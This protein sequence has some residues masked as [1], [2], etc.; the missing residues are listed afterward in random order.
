[1]SDLLMVQFGLQLLL[2]LGLL[3]W[4]ALRRHPSRAAW[5]LALVLTASVVVLLALAGLWL[6]LPWYLPAVYGLLLVPAAVPFRF[7]FGEGSRARHRAAASAQGVV[8]HEY[9]SAG[10]AFDVDTPEDLEIVAEA[11]GMAGVCS[12]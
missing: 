12:Q 10:T 8:V 11:I 7:A 2:P 9:E 6:M 5:A 1:M 3:L 4:L